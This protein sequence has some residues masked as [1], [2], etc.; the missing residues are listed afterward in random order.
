MV[1]M[2]TRREKLDYGMMLVPPLESLV[3]ARHRLRK[4][5][6]VLDLSFIHDA[7]RPLYCQD[8]GRGS[9][10][11]EV[12]M[13]LFILQAIQNIRSVRELMDEVAVNLAYRWFIGYSLAETLPDHSTLS[14]ALDRLGNEVFDALFQRSIMQCQAS[15]LI[16]GRVLHLD[17]TL[18]RA[19]LDKDKAEQPGCSD[20]DARFGRMKG[21]PGYKQQTVADGKARVVVAV[22]VMPANEHDH[23]GAVA[24]IDQAIGR[25]GQ[26]P[27]AVCADAAY[28]NGPNA[29]AMEARDVRLVSP[30][31]RPG[32]RAGQW[33]TEDFVYD[34]IRDVY[35]CPANAVLTY[36][37]TE[38]TKKR[39]RRYRAPRAVCL[40]CP[41]RSR[42]TT[43]KRRILYIGPY[44]D[45]LTRL[46][47]D[48][49][50]DS[51]RE[52]FRARAPV[53]EG[54]FAEG[55]QW[56]GLRR[57]WRR[58]LSNMLMQSL[59]VAS[60]INF[61]RLMAAHRLVEVV[62]AASTA[63][64]NLSG[65]LRSTLR[66]VSRVTRMILHLSPTRSHRLRVVT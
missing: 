48:A 20:P 15:G 23:H 38:T 63:I 11:P 12:V 58:G 3:P 6:A 31:R 41:L 54:V 27:E 49:K 14:K 30:P 51:F 35:V 59:L 42:C 61:K 34:A 10:D 28:A 37:G 2:Q 16:E 19:D 64:S 65:H 21:A 1:V 45:Y 8:N 26:R 18:I 22:D 47:A 5:N 40:E 36:M 66:R 25:I 60:V 33:T 32:T 17:A 56:H 52:L 57:A 55:K 13:R 44:H 29:A 7:V 53:I 62:S 39:R 4:L 43:S 46:R 50:T 9:V 24:T